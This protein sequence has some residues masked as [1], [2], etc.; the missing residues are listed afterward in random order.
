ME[1]TWKVFSRH[2][3]FLHHGFHAKIHSFVLMSNHFHFIVSTPDGNVSAMMRYFMTETSREITYLTGRINQTYGGPY[4]SSLI[5][6]YHY[7]LHAY[8]Y[9]YRN[10]VEAGLSDLA[11]NYK[12][13]SLHSLLGYAH[14]AFPIVEDDTLFSDISGTLN[15]INQQPD[16]FHQEAVRKALRRAEFSLPRDSNNRPNPL[17]FDRL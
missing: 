15:W 14:T 13:S 9:I 11:E 5:G 12:F 3:F 4:Y 6:S 7:F 1:E 17:E 2:L 10:P 8:K 16:A